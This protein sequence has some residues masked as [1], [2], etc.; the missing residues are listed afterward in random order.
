MAKFDVF[1]TIPLGKYKNLT[2]RE[3][4]SKYLLELLNGLKKNPRI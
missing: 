4:S 1:S 3:L 2:I